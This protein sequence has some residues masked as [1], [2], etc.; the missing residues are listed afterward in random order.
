MVGGSDGLLG[1]I[2]SFA[3]RATGNVLRFVLQ[4]DCKQSDVY[5]TTFV[6]ST[7][8]LAYDL[9]ST[10]ESERWLS[11]ST[12]FNEHDGVT[13]GCLGLKDSV[14]MQAAFPQ[15]SA[16]QAGGLANKSTQQGL[17]HAALGACDLGLSTLLAPTALWEQVWSNFSCCDAGLSLVG[18]GGWEVVWARDPERITSHGSQADYLNAIIPLLPRLSSGQYGLLE[19]D[20]EALN[21]LGFALRLLLSHGS[22]MDIACDTSMGGTANRLR[23]KCCT[24]QFD[25]LPAWG[26]FYTGMVD[27]TPPAGVGVARGMD[28]GLQNPFAPNS[29]VRADQVPSLAA[30]LRR[31][32]MMLA[33][34]VPNAAAC[35]GGFWSAVNGNGRFPWGEASAPADGFI[36]GG[37]ANGVNPMTDSI[38]RA[39][40]TT[41]THSS[42]LVTAF[43]QLWG[44]EAFVTETKQVVNRILNLSTNGPLP[45]LQIERVWGA[46]CQISFSQAVRSKTACLS[47]DGPWSSNGSDMR[48]HCGTQL[49][50]ANAAS[51]CTVA[52]DTAAA[53]NRLFNVKTQLQLRRS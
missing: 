23:L 6:D 49:G 36:A 37:G 13:V 24:H 15:Y 33:D 5:S 48:V 40:V 41:S 34:T 51:P 21:D 29:A 17:W 16:T 10:E 26:A 11:Q 19:A 35:E 14:A 52:L 45:W 42:L 32:L 46:I 18:V 20:S 50:Q 43:Q 4:A 22:P 39:S 2:S 44:K 28:C 30:Q 31:A 9:G 25:V 47:V 53:M 8:H 3:L 12:V 1:H 7:Q 27:S 38:C